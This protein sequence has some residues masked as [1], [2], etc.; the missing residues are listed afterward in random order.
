MSKAPPKEIGTRWLFVC[1]HQFQRSV[2]GLPCTIVD[3]TPVVF[4]YV[5]QFDHGTRANALDREL[6]DLP[7]STV[8]T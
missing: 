3:N 8:A 6:L 4:P 7:S 2:S 5:V 1:P